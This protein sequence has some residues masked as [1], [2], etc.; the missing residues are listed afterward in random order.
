MTSCRRIAASAGHEPAD[1]QS[2]DV[3]S[4][5]AEIYDNGSSR[6][7]RRIEV[8]TTLSAKTASRRSRRESLGGRRRGH[9][10]L[11]DSHREANRPKEVRPGR[12]VLRVEARLLGGGTNPV[13][14]ETPV[15]V[16]RS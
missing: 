12:Y 1:V 7:A 10:K 8:V 6:D 16:I 2:D 9:E 5:F 13:A 14:R 15:T 11:A 4:V 3:L